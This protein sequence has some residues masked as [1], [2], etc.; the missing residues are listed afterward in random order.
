[1]SFQNFHR[2]YAS[3]APTVKTFDDHGDMKIVLEV[4]DIIDELKMI[5]HVLVTQDDILKQTISAIRQLGFPT[6]ERSQQPS[7]SEDVDSI[8][9]LTQG[10]AG[11]TKN[12]IISADKT[13]KLVLREI[14]GINEDAQDTHRMVSIFLLCTTA[15]RPRI[16]TF[17]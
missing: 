9:S 10:L 13:L 15:R 16:L 12:H 3:G 8:T 6:M 17:P 5:R 2:G 4:A 11:L 1:M 7:R 14:A